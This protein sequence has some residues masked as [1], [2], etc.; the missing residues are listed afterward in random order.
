MIKKGHPPTGLSLIL[1]SLHH[2]LL[3]LAA[4]DLTGRCTNIWR[5]LLVY[6]GTSMYHGAVDDLAELL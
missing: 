4:S 5:A 6:T 2:R 1:V 3:N